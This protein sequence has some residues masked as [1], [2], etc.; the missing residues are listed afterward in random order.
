MKQRFKHKLQQSITNDDSYN[1]KLRQN[2]SLKS[3]QD[4][5]KLG[6]F[7]LPGPAE[8]E[9]PGGLAAAHPPSLPTLAE[10]SSLNKFDTR[11]KIFLHSR[12]LKEMIDRVR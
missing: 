8:E 2:N 4:T 7:L 9:G 10:S 5:G 6:R 3:Y 11:L 1:Y 12:P